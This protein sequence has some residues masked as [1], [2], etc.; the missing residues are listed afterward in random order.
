MKNLPDTS[1]TAIPS[2]V[3]LILLAAGISS[4]MKAGGTLSHKLLLPLAG[5]AMIVQ[6]L[7][8][9]AEIPFAERIV[10]YGAEAKTITTLIEP[11]GVTMVYN[12]QYTEGLASS[13]RCGI[14]AS[15]EQSFAYLIA[16]ADMP[17]IQP[18]SIRHILTTFAEHR[19][20]HSAPIIAPVYE[21]QRGNPVL[22]DRFYRQDL[23]LLHGDTGAQPIVRHYA[24]NLVLVNVQDEGV[25]RDIDTPGQ[26]KAFVGD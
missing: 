10:V 5:K 26:Y 21:G 15:S 22:F 6:T 16:L 11:F 25:I 23:L 20:Y 13:L 2:P 1:G 7:L 3:S 9:Y 18:H 24:D 17:F 14:K 8:R 12:E 4:R 19:R